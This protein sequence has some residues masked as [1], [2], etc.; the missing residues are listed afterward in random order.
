MAVPMRAMIMT[1]VI[2]PGMIVR[3]GVI[4]MMVMRHKGKKTAAECSA[5]VIARE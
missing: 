3:V 1:A 2:V 4:V 5:A